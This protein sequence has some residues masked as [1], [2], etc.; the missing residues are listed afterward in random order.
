MDVDKSLKASADWQ[1]D[2][3]ADFSQLRERTRKERQRFMDKNPVDKSI[4]LVYPFILVES[5]K[6]FIII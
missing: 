5:K 2:K 6:R 1:N 3:C 4:K